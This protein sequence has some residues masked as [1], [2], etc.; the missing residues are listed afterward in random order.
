MRSSSSFFFF[1][2]ARE[3]RLKR[4]AREGFR[5]NLPKTVP[6]ASTAADSD[7]APKKA[8]GGR[9]SPVRERRD[10]EMTREW[11]YGTN[12]SVV[13]AVIIEVLVLQQTA[14]TRYIFQKAEKR[15]LPTM[16]VGG[17]APTK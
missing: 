3:G 4:R 14:S 7:L 9:V 15:N 10:L 6:S 13:D 5:A 11:I 8:R 17:R 2:G 1:C 16:P 12:G